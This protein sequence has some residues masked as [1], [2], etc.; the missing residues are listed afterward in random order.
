MF[1]IIQLLGA[2]SYL[3]RVRPVYEE[4][5]ECGSHESLRLE[6]KKSNRLWT[7]Q[8]DNYKKIELN[9]IILHLQVL[10]CFFLIQVQSEPQLVATYLALSRIFTAIF[11]F[12]TT[13]IHFS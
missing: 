12:A 4:S 9:L 6:D 5:T 2:S 11:L 3:S 1:L 10:T 13:T 8:K 7:M